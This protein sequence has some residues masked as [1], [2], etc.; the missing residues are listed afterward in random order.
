MKLPMT[1]LA[2][3]ALSAVAAHAEVKTHKIVMQV[4]DNDPA[5]FNLALNNV[6]NVL[7]YY[8]ANGGDNVLIDVV[9]YGPGLNMY[10]K[11]KTPVGERIGAISLQYPNVKFSACAVTLGK[12]E[13]NAGHKIALVSEATVV[14]G[15]VIEITQDQENG[16]A[17]LKP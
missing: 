9:A 8:A 4:D 17:F 6:E 15:G 12:M 14:P 3:A 5:K 2:A 13:K 7:Q 10:V 1:I 16:Y 11:A